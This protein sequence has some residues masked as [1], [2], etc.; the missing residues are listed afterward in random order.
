M[1]SLATEF[2]LYNSCSPT[3]W[4]HTTSDF[5]N[6]HLDIYKPSKKWNFIFYVPGRIFYALFFASIF[7]GCLYSMYRFGF[8]FSRMLIFYVSCFFFNFP[9]RLK[10]AKISIPYSMYSSF[11]IYVRIYEIL[12]MPKRYALYTCIWL[13]CLSIY[14]AIYTILYSNQCI[15]QLL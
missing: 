9:G 6:K 14:Q 2:D 5:R 7:Q 11:L 12:W 3:H 8:Q 10:V 1:L 4:L 15:Y 13:I